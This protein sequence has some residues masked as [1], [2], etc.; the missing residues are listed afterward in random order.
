MHNI[1]NLSG[2]SHPVLI[3]SFFK[4]VEEPSAEEK[5]RYDEYIEV[6]TMEHHTFTEEE[7]LRRNDLVKTQTIA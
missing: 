6:P 4:K 5:E 1:V 7:L 2:A 3:Y